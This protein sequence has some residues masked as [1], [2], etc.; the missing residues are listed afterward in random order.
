M[1]QCPVF[2]KSP[3]VNGCFWCANNWLGGRKSNLIIVSDSQ[4]KMVTVSVYCPVLLDHTPVI[5]HQW[6]LPHYIISFLVQW[7]ICI[8]QIEVVHLT[9]SSGLWNWS[10]LWY[11]NIYACCVVIGYFKQ[12]FTSQSDDDSS[13]WNIW[14][15][16]YAREHVGVVVMAMIMLWL[17]YSNLGYNSLQFI[18]P[19][20]FADLLHLQRM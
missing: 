13:W 4:K 6:P 2:H 7:A 17:C 20:L 15:P 5:T 12:I 1:Y 8:L 10:L 9:A 11:H 19:R 16:E 3:I 18:Q 14:P